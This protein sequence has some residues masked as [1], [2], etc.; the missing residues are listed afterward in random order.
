MINDIDISSTNRQN[1]IFSFERPEFLL[2]TSIE[3]HVNKSL[4]SQ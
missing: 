2:I 3:E 1:N 4:A